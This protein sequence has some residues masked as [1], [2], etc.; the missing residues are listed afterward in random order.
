MVC[1]P[2]PVDGEAEAF[3]EGDLGRPAEELGG[4][5]IVGGTIERAGGFIGQ[6]LNLGVVIG[7]GEDLASGVDD[8]NAFHG[9]EVYGGGVVDFFGGEDGAG[10]DV[11]DVSPVANL[12]AGAP[13]GVGIF[14]AEGAG[15]QG[16]DG[17]AFTAAGTVDGEVAAD[18][19]FEAEFR[20]IGGE[21][22]L[23]HEFCPAVEVVGFIGRLDVVFGKE[24]LLRGVCLEGGGI[25][26]SGGG[27]DDLL[28]ASLVAGMD[29]DAIEREIAGAF[30]IVFLDEAAAAMAGGEVEDDFLAGDD[31][32][33]IEGVEEIDVAEGGEA[34]GE[35]FAA[36]AGEVVGDGDAGT[37]KEEGFDEVG[38]DKG[39]ATGDEDGSIVPGGMQFRRISRSGVGSKVTFSSY[40]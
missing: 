33:G 3:V 29:D 39:G 36:A 12:F 4:A 27:V 8:A 25:D 6:S 16:H 38:A 5:A 11:G 23:G 14:A 28:D 32:L 1:R 37:A 26:A 34:R 9:A 19:G 10:D 31:L 18:G 30:G 35:V 7:V 22:K 24:D 40:G 2:A 17:V 21:G 15:D 13:D 20:V